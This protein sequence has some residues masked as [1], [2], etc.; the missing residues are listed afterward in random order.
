MSIAR[1]AKGVYVVAGKMYGYPGNAYLVETGDN[2][3][4]IDTG[5]REQPTELLRNVLEIAKEKT[6]SIYVI[7]TSC[8][9]DAAAGAKFLVDTIDARIIVHENDST[10]LR[11]GKC[12]G[13]EYPPVSPF[14]VLR[15]N[16]IVMGDIKITRSGSPTRGSIILR[17]ND[18]LF[19]GASKL[20]PFDSRI[21]YIFGLYEYKR[22]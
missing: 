11:M 6:K 22:Y 12:A 20:S 8:L 14:M 21:K 9:R 13:E 10:G 2:F 7:L 17:N 19:V 18:S 4:L 5:G 15:E 1:I 16:R 3:Y